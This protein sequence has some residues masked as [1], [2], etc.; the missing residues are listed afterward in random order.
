MKTKNITSRVILPSKPSDVFT[1]LMNSERHS[2]FT[3]ERANIDGRAGGVF[4]CYGDYISGITLELEPDKR[5]IQAWRSRNWPKGIYSIVT[6]RLAS[7]PG[8]KTELRFSQIGVPTNDYEEKNKGWRTHY[9]E[10][11]KRFLVRL[12]RSNS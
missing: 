2:Q 4:T 11:L 7:K 6:F 10:P 12:K 5:I 9:W 3:E 1:A 8:G